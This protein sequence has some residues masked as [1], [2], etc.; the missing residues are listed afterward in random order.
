MQK[1]IYAKASTRD[2]EKI[3]ANKCR[4]KALQNLRTY[5]V[6]QTKEASRKHYGCTPRE[7]KKI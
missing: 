1:T 2:T 5:P 4:Y 6:F 3:K 7:V